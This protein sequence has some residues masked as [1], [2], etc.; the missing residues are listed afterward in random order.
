MARVLRVWLLLVLILVVAVVAG[1]ARAGFLKAQTPVQSS[2]LKPESPVIKTVSADVPAD[3][4]PIYNYKDCTPNIKFI[5]R[6]KNITKNQSESSIQACATQTAFGQ[7]NASNGYLRL[8]DTGLAGPIKSAAGSDITASAI[9]G[10]DHLIYN[11]SGL[12][13]SSRLIVRDFAGNSYIDIQPDGSIH[14]RLKPGVTGTVIKDSQGA[15]LEFRSPRFS[16]NGKW[17]VGD[18]P[19]RGMTRVNVE[20]GETLMFGGAY[21]HSI[22]IKPNFVSAVSGDGRYAFTAEPV[23]GVLKLYDL[24]DCQSTSDPVRKSCKQRELLANLQ[25]LVPGFKSIYHAQFST[26]Y[27][28][29]LYIRY[30][31]QD[32]QNRYG[33]FLLTASGEKESSLDYLALGDSFASGEGTF[34]YKSGTDVENPFNKCHL[35]PLSYPYL[36]AAKTVLNGV[37]SVACSGAKMKDIAFPDTD[38][39]YNH[40][41]KQSEGKESAGF[42]GQIYSGFLAGYRPQ[43]NFVRN[44]KPKII[45]LSISGNDI[46]FGKILASC[47]MPGTCYDTPQERLDLAYTINSKFDQIVETYTKV[48]DGAGTGSK[49]YVLG[50]PSL[51]DPEGNC[52]LNVHLNK[53]EIIFSNQIISHL[54]SVVKQSAAKAG[55]SYI[56][57]EGIFKGHRLCET[58]SS[59]VAVHGLTAGDDKTFS[60]PLKLINETVDIYLTGRESYHPNQLGHRLY[61]NAIL[62]ATNSLELP[63]PAADINSSVPAVENPNNLPPR[64]IVFKDDLIDDM[65]LAGQPTALQTENLIPSSNASIFIKSESTN[66]GTYPINNEGKLAAS[67]TVPASLPPGL[68]TVHVHAK[69]PAGEDIDMQQAVYIAAAGNNIDGDGVP[70]SDEKCLLVNSSSADEDEDGTDDAC[71]GQISNP[72]RERQNIPATSADTGNV[73]ATQP[74]SNNGSANNPRQTPQSSS[75][76]RSAMTFSNPVVL[77]NQSA[78]QPKNQIFSLGNAVKHKKYLG[79]G[80]VAVLIAIYILTR[81][82]R[83][84]KR[85]K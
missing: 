34:E 14:H 60:I 20:T 56:D 57:V 11:G 4:L 30:A 71:D 13:G 2:W 64:K 77:G 49:I 39:S 18:V 59:N 85:W 38:D 32:G 69:N 19:F 84:K 15:T 54:N 62:E 25:A 74:D 68:H 61:T 67:F 37:Q 28:L 70:N 7:M 42:E 1:L 55:V 63:A 27:S 79:L 36:L 22:G 41:H 78:G 66:I 52:A 72:P 10:S 73:P 12:Y 8:N 65:V 5:T 40:H 16:D 6:P 47:L 51:A 44:N 29:R 3:L 80:A 17:M 75:D 9:P 24:S 83:S 31:G 23:Y 26:N 45:T 53:Q 21:D 81:L 35:S 76:T 46:G 48:K 58:A 82:R 43:V 50:Y 33:Y